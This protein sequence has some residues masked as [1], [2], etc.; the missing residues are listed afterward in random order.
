MANIATNSRRSQVLIMGDSQSQ[1][2]VHKGFV[3]GRELVMEKQQ[4][5]PA[6]KAI[7]TYGSWELLGLCV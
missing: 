4:M 5:T 7:D 3:I 2:L 6:Q 1:A